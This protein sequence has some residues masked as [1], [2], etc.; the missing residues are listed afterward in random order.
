M[1]VS[2]KFLA[3]ME[4]DLSTPPPLWEMAYWT[5]TLE[6]WRKE[7]MV[8]FL[9][10][11]PNDAR[12]LGKMSVKGRPVVKD[13]SGQE[14]TL[15]LEKLSEMFP[16]DY[17]IY[18]QYERQVLEDRGD[19]Q[20]IIDRIGVKMEISLEGSIP[21]YLEWPVTKREEWERYKAERLNAKTPG[22]YPENLDGLICEYNKRD[23]SVRLG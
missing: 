14:S 9:D 5:A 7:G 23:I 1:N 21:R 17:W 16:G 20:I 2:E 8:D 11:D 22:R 4:F 6:R 18:P 15:G 3:T 10:G 12:R 19:R 13:S